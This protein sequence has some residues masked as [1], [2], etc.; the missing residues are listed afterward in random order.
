MIKPFG[1]GCS[2]CQGATADEFFNQRGLL[3]IPLILIHA[4][5]L[6]ALRLFLFEPTLIAVPCSL[7]VVLVVTLPLRSHRY[8]KPAA[9]SSLGC[10]RTVGVGVVAVGCCCCNGCTL[11]TPHRG[12]CQWFQTLQ[13]STCEARRVE[14][15]S[16][17]QPRK[18]K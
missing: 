10:C 9:R 16:Y 5:I 14:C 12:S 2:R 13:S 17:F 15:C 18:I 1:S 11:H 8:R 3:F 4:L 6:I 7:L